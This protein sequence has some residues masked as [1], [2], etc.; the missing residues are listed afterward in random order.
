[1][2]HIWMP[3]DDWHSEKY[4]DVSLIHAETTRASSRAIL[5][6]SAVST[7]TLHGSASQP[8]AGYLRDS[9]AD[10]AHRD[11]PATTSARR[12]TPAGPRS[13]HEPGAIIC[14]CAARLTQPALHERDRFGPTSGQLPNCIC[15]PELDPALGEV[16]SRMRS[17]GLRRRKLWIVAVLGLLRLGDGR[18]SSADRLGE[19]AHAH[20]DFVH[21]RVRSSFSLLQSTV[22]VEAL[23]KACRAGGMPAVAVDRRR[24]P[25]RRDAVLRRREEGRRAA[26]RGRAAGAGTARR[27]LPRTPGRPPPPEQLVLLVKD[28]EGYGNLLRLMSRA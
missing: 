18:V 23:A 8:L 3:G 21:L 6:A 5:S 10:V 20:A 17:S 27:P 16:S 28:A 13:R 24:Q 22:R 19:P 12:S 2:R 9:A 14:F 7:M 15:H 25:V 4:R 1:M 11:H 26:D